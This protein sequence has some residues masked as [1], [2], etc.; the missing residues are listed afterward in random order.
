MRA[1]Y[2]N[3]DLPALGA[4]AGLVAVGLVAIY[5][6]THGPAREFLLESVQ[7]NF[8]RQFQWFVLSGLGMGVVLLIPAR[9][10]VR[11]APLAYAVSIG[12]LVAA[13]A[14]G[15]EINGA[16]SWLQIGPASLQVAELAKVGTVLAATAWLARKNVRSAQ[17]GWN[18][19]YLSALVGV[20]AIVLLPAVL[21]VMQNDTGTGLVFISLLGVMV[22]WSGLVPLPWVALAVG[23]ALSVYLAI[24]SPWAAAAFA[25]LATVGVL[26]WTRSRWMAA[27]MFAAT[28]VLGGASRFLLFSILAPHQ[29]GRIVAFVDPEA[30]RDTAG[31]HVIQAKA[32]I[33]SGGLT[34]KGFTEGTQTQLAFIPEQSTDFVFTIIGEEFG[35]LGTGLVLALFAFLLIRLAALG[36]QTGFALPRLF[37]AG[38]TGIFFVHVLINVG[39]TVGLMP[40]IGIP[41]PFV[42]Y[43]G[44]ALLANTTMLAIALNLHAR[45]DEFAVYRA[46]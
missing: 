2:R 23:S 43:G 24:L 12:L 27:A 19:G 44:S 10:I 45:R 21:V 32:A 29:R 8:N 18:G 30:Y 5:S 33:G 39:M 11:L 4:W 9:V 35:F 34:G 38:V 6:A 26:V 22:F 41:L 13:L 28:A 46:E 42:S 15:R 17:V 31:F 1:W 14:F 3:L 37:V 40:V 36:V 25:L 16:K 7:Q 20:A